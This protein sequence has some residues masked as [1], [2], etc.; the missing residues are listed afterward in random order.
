MEG[1]LYI[2]QASCLYATI[3]SFKGHQSTPTVM[4]IYTA[5]YYLGFMTLLDLQTV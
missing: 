2:L 5:W 3:A 1:L 4:T